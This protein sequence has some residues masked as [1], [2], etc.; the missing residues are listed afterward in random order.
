VYFLKYRPQTIDDL[1]LN[2]VRQELKK[3][4]NRD[5]VPHAF[6]FAGPK[7]TGKTSAARILAKSVN[8]R[9]KDSFEPCNQCQSCQEITRGTSLDVVEIDAASNRGIDDIRELKEK[10]GLAPIKGKYKVYIIDEVHMLT[11]QAFNALLKTLEEPPSHVIFVLCTTDPDKIIP[12]VMSRL[13]RIDFHHGTEDEVKR[14]LKKV[15]DGEKLEVDKKVIDE[16]VDLSEGGFRD[17]QKMLEN[18]AL[19]LGKEIKWKEARELLGNW[20]KRRPETVIKLI[21]EKKIDELIKIGEELAEEG[22]SFSDYFKRLLGLIQ[23]LILV[24][25]KVE[26]DSQL[27]EIAEKFEVGD[28]VRLSD[29]FSEASYRQKNA[30]IS[31]LPFQLAVIKYLGEDTTPPKVEKPKKKKKKINKTVN[32]KE[33]KPD[34]NKKEI[35]ISIEEI[36]K[37][38][39]SLL[40][41]VKPMNHSVAAFLKAAQP[42]RIE[43]K[44]LILE[45]FYP[46]HKDKL[47]EH[48]NRQIVEQGVEKV[49]NGYVKIKCILGDKKKDLY[50][51]AK[52]IFG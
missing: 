49:F 29:L 4:L 37:N 32:K 34:G 9:E 5:S 40:E 38:W 39:D 50:N 2:S 3:I 25:T 14:S 28:L 8:C 21:A 6:L 17:A 22:A 27:K 31:Q 45:V 46:F 13:M 7:G 48:R 52:D 10:I 41:A 18:L 11:N 15:I 23:H 30:L 47:E 51:A 1:D 26:K 33:V 43:G 16:V 24:R 20:E 35:E 36:R 19:N 12:T 44:N 42:K